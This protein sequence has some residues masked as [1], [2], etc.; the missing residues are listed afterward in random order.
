MTL[1]SVSTKNLGDLD[2]DLTSNMLEFPVGRRALSVILAMAVAVCACPAGQARTPYTEAEL[3]TAVPMGLPA[4]RT[5]ADS[6]L[7]VLEAQVSQLPAFNGTHDFS[8]LALSGGGEHGAFGAGLLTGWSETGRRPSFSIVTGISTGA[9]MSPFAFLG[10][11]YDQRLKALYTEMSFH[12]VLA[13]NPIL[14]LFGEGLYNTRPLQRIVA[15]QVDQTMLADVAAAHRQGRRLFVVTTN[16]DAQRPVL[17][18]M[19]AI[20]NSGRPEALELFRK[21]LVASASVPGLFDPVFIDAE[22]ANGHRFNEMHVDGGTTLEVLAIP[23]RLAEAGRLAAAHRP[24]GEL[25]ILI[26]N[27]LDPAFAMTKPKTLSITARAFNSLVKSDFYDTILGSYVFANKQGFKFNL[28]YIPNSFKVRSLE[29]ID[30]NYMKALFE[31]GRAK[32]RLGGDWEHVP[33]RL[34]R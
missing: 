5:W 34:Y 1:I 28:A 2:H 26:N 19:G 11:A 3:E 27:N 15:H 22:A 25:Y 18:N 20:A 16:L 9:L 29:L 7:S 13:G 24:Q 33:P 17:W 32:G 14:G 10:S 30:P 21:V 4:V 6:P 8:I 23:L 31:F 12:T